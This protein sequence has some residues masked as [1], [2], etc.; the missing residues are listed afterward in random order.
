VDKYD[1][2][3]FTMKRLYEIDLIYCNTHDMDDVF[4]KHLGKENVKICRNQL[5]VI[6]N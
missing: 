3:D 5:G 2:E 4:T 1:G 6:E